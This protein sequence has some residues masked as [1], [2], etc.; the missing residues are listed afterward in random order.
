MHKRPVA[1]VWGLVLFALGMAGGAAW[2]LALNHAIYAPNFYPAIWMECFGYYPLYLPALVWLWLSGTGAVRV[3][4]RLASLVGAAALFAVSVNNLQKRGIDNGVLHAAAVWI[5]LLALALWLARTL[6]RS[7]PELSGRLRTAMGWAVVYMVLDNVCINVLKL[8]WNR[9]R[10]DEMLATGNFDAFTSWFEPFGNGG[11][12]FPS[13]HTAAACGIFALVLLCDVLPA[14]NRRRTA[15]WAVCWCY[16]AG[17]AV[18]RLM[19]GRHFLSDTLA[20]AFVMS[21]LLFGL[22]TSKAYQ[23]SLHRFDHET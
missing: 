19:M 17:M 2:D 21:L 12:S 5:V 4:A 10:F 18:S 13:G 23:D 20:A 7:G 22:R 9:A 14:W 16:V 11:S 1:W 8:V 15:V 6:A 3:M